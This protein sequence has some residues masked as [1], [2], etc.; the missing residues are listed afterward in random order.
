[1]LNCEILIIYI[2]IMTIVSGNYI[3]I[4]NYKYIQENKWRNIHV[5]YTQT[6]QTNVAVTN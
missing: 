6:K 4:F 1:M 3:Q 5:T 2:H